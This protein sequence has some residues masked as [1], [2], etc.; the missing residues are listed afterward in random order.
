MTEYQKLQLTYSKLQYDHKLLQ[1]ENEAI[2]REI[3]DLK[4]ELR[5]VQLQFLQVQPGSNEIAPENESSNMTNKH[6]MMQQLSENTVT[7]FRNAM[8]Q[9]NQLQ[10]DVDWKID[11]FNIN[12]SVNIPHSI[13]KYSADRVSSA[14]MNLLQEIKPKKGHVSS[15]NHSVSGI[16]ATAILK[17]F[18]AA[19][20]LTKTQALS[21]EAQK[22][23][24]HSY[25]KICSLREEI[26]SLKTENQIHQ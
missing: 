20:Y 21:K 2:K 19:N 6:L 25:D 8:D 16:K 22:V 26:K 18:Q 23:I 10:K 4:K 17:P 3:F 11:Q 9:I 24:T 14:Y 5:S 13:E 12:R 1:Q 15:F 7:Q